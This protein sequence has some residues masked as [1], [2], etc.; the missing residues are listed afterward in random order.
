MGIVHTLTATQQHESNG[1][2]ERRI[3]QLFVTVRANLKGSNLPAYLWPEAAMASAHTQNLLVSTAL[4]RRERK[5]GQKK[6]QAVGVETGSAGQ[7]KTQA[8][9][10]PGAG[11]QERRSVAAVSVP[12][13]HDQGLAG[14]KKRQANPGSAGQKK[15]QADQPDGAGVQQRRSAT[16][17]SVPEA[18]PDGDG[19]QRRRSAAEAPEPAV[20]GAQEQRSAPAGPGVEVA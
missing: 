19:V 3:G 1:L 10:V 16:V 14:Q 8:D 17:V 9:P 6:K 2:A 13:A 5:A 4:E 15:R 11:A 12:A 20:H 7:K 18:Q